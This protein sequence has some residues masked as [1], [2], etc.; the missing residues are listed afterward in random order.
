MGFLHDHAFV[1][2]MAT[3][4]EDLFR[5]HRDRGGSLGTPHHDFT[6]GEIAR[7]HSALK[8]GKEEEIDARE[9]RPAAEPYFARDPLLS[10][11]QSAMHE[12]AVK[13]AEAGAPAHEHVRMGDDFTPVDIMGWGVDVGLSLIGRL[14]EGSYPFEDAP[15]CTDRPRDPRHSPRNRVRGTEA[16]PRPVAVQDRPV[17][18]PAILGAQR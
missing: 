16:C 4:L 9:G 15:A 10:L 17:R 12:Q 7:I 18:P 13:D 1:H 3:K 8:R 5:D 6:P 11:I 14:L 2:E